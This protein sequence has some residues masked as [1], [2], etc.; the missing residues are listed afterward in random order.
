[1]LE[2]NLPEQNLPERK[3]LTIEFATPSCAQKH[4]NTANATFQNPLKVL[5][6]SKRRNG[7]GLP[8]PIIFHPAGRSSNIACM[9]RQGLYQSNMG[10]TTPTEHCDH[11]KL[12][13]L[14]RKTGKLDSLRSTARYQLLTDR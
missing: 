9:A 8:C 12:I 14:F 2:Q 3:M 13:A 1:V 10:A 7:L 5:A 11:P 6:E 4:S